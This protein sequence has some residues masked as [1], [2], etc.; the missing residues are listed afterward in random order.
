LEYIQFGKS[1]FNINTGKQ[2]ISTP[3]HFS[4]NQIPWEPSDTHQTPEMDRLITS[5]VG[6]EYLQTVYEIIA[7]CTYRDYPIH[8]IFC[9]VGTGANGKTRLLKIIER[10]VG[11][12]NKASVTLKKIGNNDFALYPLYR[13]TVCFV[14]ETAHH[15][16]ESTEILKALSGQDPVSFEDKGRTAFTGQNYAKMIVGTNVLPPSSDTSRGWYRRWFVLR[17]PN[18]FD[19]TEDVLKRIP[20]AE[21]NALARKTIMLLPALLRRGG[22][23]NEG[24]IEDRQARYVQ[25]SNPLKEF[26]SLFYER[27][28]NSKVRYT[29]CY[30]DYLQFLSSRKLRKVSKREF[31]SALDDESLETQKTSTRDPVTSETSSFNVIWGLRRLEEQRSFNEYSRN[32]SIPDPQVG[33]IVTSSSMGRV[34]GREYREYGN[35]AENIIE[36]WYDWLNKQPGGTVTKEELTNWLMINEP[37]TSIKTLLIN[38]EI[39]EPRPGIVRSVLK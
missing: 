24:T 16:L 28:H 1:F 9:F 29:E 7:Y 23:Y 19:E 38:G 10:F 32:P 30:L 21:Y 36:K 35:T 5:W 3:E 2:T 22:F 27:D 26:I 20:D 13:K 11:P 18:E 4:T 33:S 12:N 8:R 39:Y 6:Q 31:S 17:F 15:R 25:N 34:G 14:G 37:T